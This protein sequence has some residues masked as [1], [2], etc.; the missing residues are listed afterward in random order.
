M[1][2]TQRLFER[3]EALDIPDMKGAKVHV[4][5]GVTLFV[6]D[7]KWSF[8]ELYIRTDRAMYASKQTSGNTLTFSTG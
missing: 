6:G 4:S 7:R 5:V 3:L 2:I 1:G 8:D